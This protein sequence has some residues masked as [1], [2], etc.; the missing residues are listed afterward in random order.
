M[1][2]RPKTTTRPARRRQASGWIIAATL[3]LAMS[4]AAAE[5]LDEG[6]WS[7]TLPTDPAAPCEFTTGGY[8]RT[9]GEQEPLLLIVIERDGPAAALRVNVITDT[10]LTQPE[11]L[12]SRAVLRV[13]GP[14]RPSYPL[15]P[16]AIVEADG[17]RRVTLRPRPSGPEQ[18]GLRGLVEAMR[19]GQRVTVEING[20]VLQPAFSMRG[21]GSL[22]GRG[23][24]RCGAAG[25]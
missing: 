7:A 19:G 4:A 16:A 6:A 5:R 25:G 22:W 17:K 21:L 10:D 24:A 20:R 18:A 23:E 11:L 8:N 13:Q 15:L 14:R 1:P 12:R 9:A 3:A 2:A